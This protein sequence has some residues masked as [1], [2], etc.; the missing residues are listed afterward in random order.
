MV[1][2]DTVAASVLILVRANVKAA[3]VIHVAADVNFTL[4]KA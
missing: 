4:A 1:V 3:A 2:Q